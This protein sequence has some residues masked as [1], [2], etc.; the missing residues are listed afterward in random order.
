MNNLLSSTWTFLGEYARIA[1]MA[2]F[3]QNTIFTRALGSSTSL[4]LIRKKS[5]LPLFGFIIIIMTTLSSF[6]VYMVSDFISSFEFAEY[7]RPVSYILAIAISYLILLLIV[8]LSRSLR[9]KLLPIIHMSAFNCAI[10]GA[11]LLG[12][13]QHMM[14]TQ[15]LGFGI[16]SGLGFV[17]ATAL[18]SVAYDKLYNEDIPASFRGFPVTL[19]Y[20]GILSLAFYGLTGHELPF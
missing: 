10:L 4:L 3:L 9:K 16:G 20:I 19:I 7:I 17:L 6:G 12:T 2:I 8:S 11:L 14:L 18:I 15:F 1:L 5:N 13:Q